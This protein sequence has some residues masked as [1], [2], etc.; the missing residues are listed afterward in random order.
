MGNA[1]G[2]AT[3]RDGRVGAF[4][5]LR[6]TESRFGVTRTVLG[7]L[8][9]G[10]NLVCTLRIIRV[11]ELLP[12]WVDSAMTQPNTPYDCRFLGQEELLRYT[13]DPENRL[14]E[15]FVR[16]ALAKGDRCFGILD[17]ETLASFGW[18]SH[19]PTKIG[20]DGSFEF[21]TEFVYMFHG[22]TRPAYRG[23]RLH[24]L[25]LAR[26]VQAFGEEGYH[27]LV[28]L[29]EPTNWPSRASSYGMGFKPF[30][31][32]VEVG[33]ADNTRYLISRGARSRG[34]HVSRE[35][36]DHGDAP[37][38]PTEKSVIQQEREIANAYAPWYQRG[39][40]SNSFVYQH[41]RRLFVDWALGQLRADGLDPNR[42][43]YLDLGCG[44]G[45]IMET[46]SERG[47]SDLT[48]I[49]I[50]EGML[51]EARRSV[52]GM[53]WIQGALEAVPLRE[54][55]FDVVIAS[56]TVH[57]LADTGTFAHAVE[58]VLRPGGWC[59]VLEYEASSPTFRPRFRAFTGALVSPFRFAWKRKN[60]GAL[61]RLDAPI[62]GF[63]SAHRPRTLDEIRGALSNPAR[64]RMNRRH[65]G[66]LIPQMHHTLVAGSTIDSW[67]LRAIRGLE[68]IFSP[69][70][71]GQLQWI[72]LRRQ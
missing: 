13:S 50:S 7:A 36:T 39:R 5:K 30:G 22:Y 15:Q 43:R 53:R 48:G 71:P 49:D 72:A 37:I 27:G 2:K 29:L 35:R 8:L 42:L 24:S 31:T 32:L 61:A 26:A 60:A 46:L 33:L 55:T 23:Q 58:R 21:P 40:L 20:R 65:H 67:T 54:N 28:S 41:E 14:S 12:A 66:Y 52:D 3:A 56:F 18:Y 63:S 62:P 11:I 16:T 68:R 59:F 45:N 10:I 25:G 38:K 44:P 19:C 4:A 47:C 1:E 6:S 70:G 51:A 57:H 17:G 64:W 34:C 69:L 9:N